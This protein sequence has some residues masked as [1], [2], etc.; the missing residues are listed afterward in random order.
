MNYTML[1]PLHCVEIQKFGIISSATIMLLN[2]VT[3]ASTKVTLNPGRINEQNIE[4]E[5]QRWYV[6][7]LALLSQRPLLIASSVSPKALKTD[8]R[9]WAGPW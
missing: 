6:V 5:A 4:T 9:I 2:H 1:S 7:L 8:E 3:F